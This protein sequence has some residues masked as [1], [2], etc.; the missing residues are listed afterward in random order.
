M[1]VLWRIELELKM[2]LTNWSELNRMKFSKYKCKVFHLKG[3]IIC[4]NTQ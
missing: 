3:K 4:T 1:Q 2:I